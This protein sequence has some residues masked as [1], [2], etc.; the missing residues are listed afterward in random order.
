MN[1]VVD[2]ICIPM[3]RIVII[4]II[5]NYNIPLLHKKSAEVISIAVSKYVL[6]TFTDQVFDND[7]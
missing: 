6:I 2:L 7:N 5:I 3:I 1:T 4:L